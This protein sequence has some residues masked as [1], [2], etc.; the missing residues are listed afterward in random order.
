MLR[1]S[2]KKREI[3]FLKEHIPPFFGVGGKSTK[4]FLTKDFSI[5]TIRQKTFLQETFKQN[6]ISTRDYWIEMF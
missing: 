2:R 6:Y 4:V 5:K 1:Q 3:F